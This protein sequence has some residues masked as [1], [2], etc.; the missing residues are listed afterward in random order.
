MI[1]VKKAYYGLVKKN[2]PDV[3]KEDPNAEENFKMIVKAYEILK[4]PVSR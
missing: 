2:H 3:N 1:E 4:D